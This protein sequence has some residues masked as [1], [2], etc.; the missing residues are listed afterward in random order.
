MDKFSEDSILELYKLIGQNVKKHRNIKNMTQLDLS[1]EMGYK[2][3]S[4]VS[5]AELNNDNTHFNIAHLY[6]ISKILDI[7]MCELF[8]S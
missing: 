5:A 1:H 2:S 6:K 7:D 3:V 4:L 8:K